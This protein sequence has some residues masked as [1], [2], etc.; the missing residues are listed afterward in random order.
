MERFKT[1]LMVALIIGDIA[2]GAACWIKEKK[3]AE[4]IWIGSFPMANQHIEWTGAGYQPMTG[5]EEGC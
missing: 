2:L 1:A 3:E 5:G 4:E